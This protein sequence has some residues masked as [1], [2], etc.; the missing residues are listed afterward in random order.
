MKVL[1][2]K[3]ASGGIAIGR[4]EF[5]ERVKFEAE[6]RL[7]N[8][9]GAE[10]ARFE[11]ACNTAKDQLDFLVAKTV[12]RLGKKNAE[13]FGV[14]K[15]MLEDEDFLDAV[16]GL[17]KND[18]V[19]AEYAVV[20]TGRQF[21]A[22]FEQID[23]EYM[24]A[25][26][27]DVLD[28]S[29]RVLGILNGVQRSDIMG[30]EPVILAADDFSPSETAQFDR[31]MV[32]GLATQAGSSNSHTS[33]FARTMGIPAVIGLGSALSP[34][35]AHSIAAL[36][37]DTGLLY[38]DPKPAVL[39]DLKE[40][41]S[42]LLVEVQALERF[43]GVPTLTKSG[44]KI[45]LFANIG[46]VADA[47]A[48]VL[49][50]AEGIGLF[51]SEFLYLECSDY[52]TEER[53]YEA[54]K[55]TLEKMNGRQVIIRTLDI[56]ADK[57]AAYFKLPMEE[58]PA[59]GLRAIRICLTRP[60]VFKTQLRAIYRASVHGNAAVMLPMI[61]SLEDVRRA[62]LIVEE[63]RRELS[64][65]RI[66][67]DRNVPIGIMIETPASAVISDLLA[68]EVEF[69]SIG[70]NDLTQY[71][72]AVDRQNDAMT[73]FCDTRHEAII[74]LI[75]M[76]VENAHKASIEVGICGSLGADPE[77]TKTF[78]DIG[79]DELSVVPSAILKLRKN[80]AEL[81]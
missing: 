44:R 46:S 56:G 68:R 61:N 20:E 47:D 77:L 71:T 62:K 11:A 2:G 63:V 69:F 64:S 55:K 72:L 81:D 22:D 67:F 42:K 1:N 60:D 16:N 51:R 48:A 26:A 9:T 14:H 73:E 32:L 28:V 49:G 25:R 66:A 23:D 6:R 13:L 52:P 27:A 15:M 19:C 74:R 76:T 21:A 4:M 37:G 29:G 12:A 36:D 59:M 53:Q 57:Q 50:D 79:I 78:V 3:G 58:N 24:R 40:K 30:Q 80:I 43:R 41:Q 54:Y 31:S 8:D 35:L 34:G 7:V 70:T 39:K 45:K 75:R 38:T 10:L 33:I 17:I 5:F 65:E 18:S